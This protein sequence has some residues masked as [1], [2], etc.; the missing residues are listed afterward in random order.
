MN[1]SDCWFTLLQGY[2]S[3]VPG[4]EYFQCPLAAAPSTPRHRVHVGKRR[5][6]FCFLIEGKYIE[7]ELFLI[8]TEY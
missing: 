3:T 1:V 8:I 6:P 4:G 5:H 2:Y 7:L